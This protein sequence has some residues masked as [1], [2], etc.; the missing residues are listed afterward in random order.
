MSDTVIKLCKCNMLRQV[1]CIKKKEK[2]NTLQT[3][4]Q[5]MVHW[6][7]NIKYIGLMDYKN[8][9]SFLEADAYPKPKVSKH[10]HFYF[11]LPPKSEIKWQKR[12]ITQYENYRK[13]APYRKVVTGQVLCTNFA[14]LHTSW[15]L[16]HVTQKWSNIKNQASLNLNT[17]P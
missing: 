4:I 13:T 15:V 8:K 7:V 11:T 16:S 14:M 1:S 2:I 12:Y 9:I 17:V 3:V 10:I 6:S 5:L